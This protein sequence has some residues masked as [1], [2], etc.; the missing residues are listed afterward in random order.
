MLFFVYFTVE[1]QRHLE[2]IQ[3]LQNSLRTLL[4][5]VSTFHAE[6]IGSTYTCTRR[7]ILYAM[8]ISRLPTIIQTWFFTAAEDDIN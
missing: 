3:T 4:H 7:S 1:L 2:Q 6:Y 5:T 8:R